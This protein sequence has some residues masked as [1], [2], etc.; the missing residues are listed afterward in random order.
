MEAIFIIIILILSVVIHE[1]SHGY[2][3]E[4]LG[5]PTARLAGRLTLNPI[6]HLDP[7]G[8]F[9]VPLLMWI[10]P[11]NF[12][13]GWAKPVPYNPYNLRNQR[14]GELLVAAAGPASN[15]LLAILFGLVVRFVSV[16]EAML[17]V[18]LFIVWINLILAIF[19]LIP[20]P[21][22]DGSKILFALLP[23]QYS[24]VR[25]VLE[26]YG[27]IIIL[28]FIVF[29]GRLIVPVVGVFFSLLTGVAF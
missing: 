23:Y 5:D 12:I 24:N 26:R 9:I 19:N 16:G 7:V 27:L 4:R 14:W 28:F 10:L 11:G 6:K 20:V 2:M 29:L 15:I 1:V 17:S 21:P 22:L 25:A 8:S 3:A 18:L 13:F